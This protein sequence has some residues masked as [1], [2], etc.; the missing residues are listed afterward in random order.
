MRPR[1]HPAD[2]DCI[3]EL[4]ATDNKGA[5]STA[6]VRIPFEP[7]DLFD[8]RSSQPASLKAAAFLC[9][10]PAPVAKRVASA[11]THG[12]AGRLTLRGLFRV[13]YCV[14]EAADAAFQSRLDVP[15]GGPSAP[16]E[17][18]PSDNRE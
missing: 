10:R 1:P 9:L 3:F 2:G 13:F 7:Y 16:S 17:K 12:Y 11:Q 4:K 18:I 6:F 8:P 15:P 14:E 5:S